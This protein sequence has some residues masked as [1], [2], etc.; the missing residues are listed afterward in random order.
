MEKLLLRTKSAVE[1]CEKHLT[2]SNAFGTEIESYLTQFLLVVL[3]SDIQQ[4]IYRLSEA[5]ASIV[6]DDAISAYVAATARRVLRSVGKED[7][8]KFVGMFGP[9]LKS[10]L[11]NL[12][13]DADVTIFNNAVNNRH[14]IAHKQ[15]AQIT[16]RELKNAV[17][18]AQKILEAVERSLEYERVGRLL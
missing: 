10:K 7:I 9:T 11:N 13:D 1:D 16:F 3:C 12:V 15:G 17:V 14:D 2:A 8:A 4:E 18:V 5:R 6:E